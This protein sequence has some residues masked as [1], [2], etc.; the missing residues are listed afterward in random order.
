MQDKKYDQ[1][2]PHKQCKCLP[3]RLRNLTRQCGLRASLL[4]LL[5]RL[6][7]LQLRLRRRLLGLQIQTQPKGSAL[8]TRLDQSAAKPPSERQTKK[9]A[10]RGQAR[11]LTSTRYAN[12]RVAPAPA[13]A[14]EGVLADGPAP[15]QEPTPTW[16][17]EKPSRREGSDANQALGCECHAATQPS[18]LQQRQ[19]SV[20]KE[21]GSHL[22][23]PRS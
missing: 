19:H 15:E 21:A 12:A 2:Q 22:R 20:N 16:A 1:K 7:K 8:S 5:L 9:N 23:L 17:G 14:C 18:R 4:L 11:S 13:A 6:L 3:L 10:T